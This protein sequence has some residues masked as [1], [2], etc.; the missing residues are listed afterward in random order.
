MVGLVLVAHSPELVRGLRAM[1]AQAAPAVPVGLAAGSAQGRLGTSAPQVL[2][3]LQQTLA[4]SRGDGAVVLVDLGSAT[5]AVEI[6]LEETTEAYRRLTRLSRGP[7]VE[8][9]IFA[10]IEAAAGAGLEGVLAAA[11]AAADMP[12]F[13]GDERG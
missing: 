3:A 10:A 11:D 6:A 7:I 4:A 1:V 12:K 2:E 8:G 9:A 5:M 13:P